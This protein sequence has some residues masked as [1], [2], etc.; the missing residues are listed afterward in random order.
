VKKSILITG[1]NGSGKTSIAE[2]L[3]QMGYPTCDMD[4]KKGL[5][6][7]VDKKTGK[8]FTDYDNAHLEKVTEMAWICDKEKLAS[9]IANETEPLAFYCGSASNI[10]DILPLFDQVI[11]LKVD[12]KTTRERLTHRENKNTYGKTAEV[13]DYIVSWKESWENK[14]IE[15]GAIMV[16]AHGSLDEI[17][18]KILAIIKR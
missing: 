15:K 1:V 7:M 4:R 9:L 11:L 12:E 13:Q 18:K 16:D 3:K 8:P 5:F 2:K 10:N 6:V 17:V 14:M